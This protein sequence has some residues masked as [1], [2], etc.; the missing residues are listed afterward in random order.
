MLAVRFALFASIALLLAPTASALRVEP[1]AWTPGK[2]SAQPS[3]TALPEGGFLLNWQQREGEYARL[4]VARLAAGADVPEMRAD[5]AHGRDWFLNWADFPSLAV[6]DNGDWVGFTLRRSARSPGATDIHLQRST[7]GGASWSAPVRVDAREPAGQRGF[8]A[9][10][11]DGED[12]ALLVWLDA[13]ALPG[14]EAPHGEAHGHDHH[15]HDHGSAMRLRAAVFGRDGQPRELA[16]LDADTCSCCPTD[17]VRHGG[18][19]LAVYRD[20]AQGIRDIAFVRRNHEGRWQAPQP[21]HVDGWRM[22]GCPV[23]GPAA[24]VN[25]ERLAVAWSTMANGPM[26]VKLALRPA[27]GADFAVP[28]LLDSGAA[29]LGR[30]D[31]APWREGGFLVGWVGGE[32]GD[33]V[34]R[35]AE[36]DAGGR[37][38]G[39]HEVTRLP[40]G[41]QL[42]QPRLA[43]SGDT[44]LLVWT[45]PGSAGTRVR[46]ARLQNREQDQPSIRPSR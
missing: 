5:L 11:A 19:V 6:L 34:L 7:D 36:V 10:L 2:G 21:V 25:G 18:E 14:Q 29:V 46:L 9:L 26:Q 15:G 41:R 44:A 23:N 39:Q 17:L 3:V 20:H 24:A 16:E 13:G 27:P 12:R 40:P 45:E 33:A 8:A 38:V 32:G 1:L 30:V 42:G 31:V 4:R 35:L 28:L 37:L 22:P 43:A